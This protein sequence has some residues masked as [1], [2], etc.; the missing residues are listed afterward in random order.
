MGSVR[1]VIYPTKERRCRVLANE[2]DQHMRATRMLV[3]KTANIVDKAR[4]EDEMSLLGL[5]LDWKKS[6]WSSMT[7]EATIVTHSSPN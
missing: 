6:C 4:D 7:N 1:M 3:D 5:F 2:F